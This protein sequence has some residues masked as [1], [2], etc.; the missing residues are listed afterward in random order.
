MLVASAVAA[1]AAQKELRKGGLA[2]GEGLLK[3]LEP[4]E[5]V[6][7][8]TIEPYSAVEQQGLIH[9]V[10]RLSSNSTLNRSGACTNCPEQ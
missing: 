10:P 2:T 9:L 3:G 7:F 5:P 4:P 6:F 8:R 1:D